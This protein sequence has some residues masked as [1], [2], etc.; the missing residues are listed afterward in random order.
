M[1]LHHVAQVGVLLLYIIYK[2]TIRT[3]GTERG[4][5]YYIL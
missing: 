2:T 1:V 5:N 4:S 3:C